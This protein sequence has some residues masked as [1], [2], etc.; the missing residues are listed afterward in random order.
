MRPS[1][2]FF[3]ML[4]VCQSFAQNRKL[5]AETS[6]QNV[7]IF[8]SGAQVVRTSGVAI[9]PGRTEVIFSGLS[10]QLEQ[11][12][13]QLKADA[14]ITLLSVQ[15]TKDFLS[16]R[17][18]EQD[19]RE[20]LEKRNS[21]KEKIELDNKLFEVYKNEEAMLVKNQSIGGQTGVKTTELKE[22]LDLQR[23]RLT[24]VYQKQLEIQK[25]LQ[26]QQADFERMRAQLA[27]ISRKKDSVNYVVTAL[28]DSKESRNVK[29]SLLYTV[30]D[31]GWYPTYD[32][33]VND[34]AQP[35][36]VLMNANVFQRSGETWKDVE[37]LLSTGNPGDN[38]TPSALQAWMLN[39]YDP[40]I[41]WLRTK[42]QQPGTASGR[43]VNERGEPVVG[44]SVT[45]RGTATSTTADANGYFKLQSF[46]QNSIAVISSV[47]Y[48]SRQIQLKPGYFTIQL[49]EASHSL[50]D[51][52]VVGY[53]APALEGRVAGIDASRTSKQVKQEAIQTVDVSTQYQPTT[54][55]YKIDEKYTLETDG[56]TTTIGIKSVSI[57]TLYEYYSAP[58]LDPAAYLTAKV[59]NWQDYDLQSGEA[60]LYFEGTFLGK[61][62]IDLAEISD[63]LSIALGKDNNVKVSRRLVKEMSSKSLIGGNR[64]ESRKYETTIRNTKKIPVNIIVQDGLPVSVNKEI[65]VDATHAPDAKVDKETG[66]ATWKFTLPPATEKKLSI[67][68]TVKYPKD[69]K[70]IVE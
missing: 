46:P 40:S 19:E 12:S 43:V 50:D 56:K 2:F 6:V 26:A 59:V 69:K 57:P 32:V 49:K 52:V 47:G 5:N 68:Y 48:Q 27:E 51:V 64:T 24:E 62:Y 44:A 45:I 10:N 42:G 28:I 36:S 16:Q 7:T 35:L 23:L 65:D 1:L 61:S 31:A 54:V 30:R 53:G 38:A 60:S 66:I 4:L 63:T 15:T 8:S 11:Q 20:L 22:A 39:F 58:K 67:D 9:L 70:V 13:V 55:V 14:N 18:I 37:L 34:I 29:F 33:R 21:L 41:T 3:C 25:R 17:K